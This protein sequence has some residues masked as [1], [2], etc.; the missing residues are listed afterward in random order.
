MA[1]SYSVVMNM[2]RAR[3][4]YYHT[5]DVTYKRVPDVFECVCLNYLGNPM[6]WYYNMKTSLMK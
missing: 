1:V 2:L 5:C 6:I 3:E 4:V